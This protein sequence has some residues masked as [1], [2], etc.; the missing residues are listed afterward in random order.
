MVVDIVYKACHKSWARML[1]PSVITSVLRQQNIYI[2]IEMSI[3]GSNTSSKVN[4]NYTYICHEKCVS[5][6]SERSHHLLV[7]CGPYPSLSIFVLLED[8]D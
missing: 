2:Y 6:F 3:V 5:F 7:V 4:T 1:H 8:C